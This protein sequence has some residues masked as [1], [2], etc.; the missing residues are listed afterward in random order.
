MPAKRLLLQRDAFTCSQQPPESY[1]YY[2]H[3]KARQLRGRGVESLAYDG[4]ED[5]AELSLGQS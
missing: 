3:F 2:P 4:Q 1:D 5:A